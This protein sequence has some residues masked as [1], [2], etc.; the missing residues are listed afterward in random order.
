MENRIYQ[1]E[2]IITDLQEK[3]LY[4]IKWVS[5]QNDDVFGSSVN[6]KWS[7]AQQIS[8]LTISSSALI[9]ILSKPKFIMKQMFGTSNRDTRSYLTVVEKYQRKLGQGGVATSP[10]MPESFVASDKKQVMGEFAAISE[11]LERL[12]NKF[13][14]DDLDKYIL[15]HPLLGKMPLR[16]M[17]FFTIYH[18]QHHTNAI[19]ELY[20][21]ASSD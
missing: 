20:G 5:E 13:S 9:K 18:T 3:S 21:D 8:H 17:F 7:T 14:E 10:F 12:I 19:K 2:E 1:K 15:P 11:K 16:E 6:E 4:L